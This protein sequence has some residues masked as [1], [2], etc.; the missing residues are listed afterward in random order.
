MFRKNDEIDPQARLRLS[1]VRRGDDDDYDVL[2][3]AVS[4]R[5]LARLDQEQESRRP[6]VKREAEEDWGREK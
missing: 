3:L 4:F 5:P 1:P 6:A 2:R